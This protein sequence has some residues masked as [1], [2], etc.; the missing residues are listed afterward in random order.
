[1]GCKAK[2]SLVGTWTGSLQVQGVGLDL[3]LR[4]ENGGTLAFTQTAAG[5]TSTQKGL[6]KELESSFTFSPTAVESPGLPKESIDQINAALAA[7]PQTVTFS[8]EWKDPDTIVVAQQGAP[9]LLAAPIT[10]K[11]SKS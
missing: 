6:Y 5:Q 1:M 3:S 10:L 2:P 4:F 8:L 11:R 7:T 9:S